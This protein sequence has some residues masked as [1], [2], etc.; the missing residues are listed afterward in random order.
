MLV[1]IN[2]IKEAVVKMAAFAEARKEQLQESK[3]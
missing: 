2:V 1:D 3:K